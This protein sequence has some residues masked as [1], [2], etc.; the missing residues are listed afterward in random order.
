M[1]HRDRTV[2]D[3]ELYFLSRLPAEVDAGDHRRGR[4]GAHAVAARNACIR[5]GARPGSIRSRRCVMN[6]AS[7]TTFTHR[8]RRRPI[9]WPRMRTRRSCFSRRR[10]AR[11]ARAQRC[12]KCSRTPSLR[13]GPA[14][15]WRWWRRRALASRR[16]LHVAGLLEHPDVGEVYVD[17]IPTS[18]MADAERTRIRRT[19]I[20]FVYQFHHLLP[21][22]SA[23]ENIMLPQMIRGPRAQGGATGDRWSFCAYLGLQA[24]R[25]THRPAE[26][27][28]GEQQRSRS[29][30]R[31]P[32][33]RASCSPMSRPEI[34]IRRQPIMCSRRSPSSC[35]RLRPRHALSPPTTWI[36]PPAWTGASRCAMGWW[37]RRE[38]LGQ[39][40][41][42]GRNK[43]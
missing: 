4:D 33:R 3:P 9:R 31:L 20:G 36:S 1:V 43:I 40:P 23:V 21:E 27:S 37:L 2:L 14:S 15:R 16:S 19:E 34:W 18:R 13:S 32:M 41:L 42:D 26:L 8:S 12:S 7:T 28:G 6:D 38:G 10:L 30:A 25:A 5:P 22:F 17:K 35:A 29:H 24:T 39:A 11:T